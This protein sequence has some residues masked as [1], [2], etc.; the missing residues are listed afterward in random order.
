MSCL[1]R[2]LFI[3]ISVLAVLAAPL[4]AYTHA[5]EHLGGDAQRVQ[6]S[7][8]S[9]DGVCEIC[10][11]NAAGSQTSA[12]YA[13]L[14]PQLRLRDRADV[15]ERPEPLIASPHRHQ[16]RAPPFSVAA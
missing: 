16:Q 8:V 4:D 14:A 9:G 10:V 5:L 12:S 7:T 6:K 15:A 3:C 13:R 11:A 2:A 1:L